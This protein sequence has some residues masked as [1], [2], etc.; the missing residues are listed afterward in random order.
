[1]GVLGECLVIGNC[2]CKHRFHKSKVVE[3]A[4]KLCDTLI[5]GC[6]LG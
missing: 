1:M 4:H 3:I 6:W 2:T 5:P